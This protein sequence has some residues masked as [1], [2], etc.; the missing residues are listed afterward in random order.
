MKYPI[1]VRHGTEML[2]PETCASS[3]RW[4]FVARQAEHGRSVDVDVYLTD[5]DRQIRW[6]H[7][8]EDG[9]EIMREKLTNA[10]NELTKARAALG[11][12][13]RFFNKLPE[14]GN[15]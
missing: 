6:S 9:P 13:E 8:G 11:P 14:N 4:M 7:Y 5:C 2:H 12:V 10:I 1:M 15:G 3:I